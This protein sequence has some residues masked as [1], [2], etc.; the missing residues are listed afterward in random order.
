MLL[1]QTKREPYRRNR[2]DKTGAGKGLT[3]R[4]YARG[5]AP[6]YSLK[7]ILFFSRGILQSESQVSKGAGTANHVG[8]SRGFSGNTNTKTE[9]IFHDSSQFLMR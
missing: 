6:L 1:R 8:N 2:F 3:G 4:D 5:G 7:T 9:Q